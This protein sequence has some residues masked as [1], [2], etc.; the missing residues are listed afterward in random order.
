MVGFVLRQGLGLSAVGVVIGLALAFATTRLLSG[1]LWGIS[2]TDPLVFVGA[3][4]LLMLVAVVASYV[5]T[6]EALKIDPLQVLRQE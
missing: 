4:V 5:P 3:P 1:L 6:R 2:A